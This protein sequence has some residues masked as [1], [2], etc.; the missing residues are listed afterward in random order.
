MASGRHP[1]ADVLSWG[2]L[3]RCA[4]HHKSPRNEPAREPAEPTRATA[5]SRP[6]TAKHVLAQRNAPAGR[7]IDQTS[8]VTF[9]PAFFFINFDLEISLAKSFGAVGESRTLTRLLLVVFETTAY[10]IPPPRHAADVK[11]EDIWC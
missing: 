7:H 5:P 11:Q 6:A 1:R 8:I 3:F 9:G 4:A 10:T 2:D